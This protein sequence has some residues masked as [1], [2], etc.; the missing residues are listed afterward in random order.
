M[1]EA[2]KPKS[3]ADILQQNQDFITHLQALQ[4]D[5]GGQLGG[6]DPATVPLPGQGRLAAQDL[7]VH[8][9]QFR[10]RIGTELAPQPDLDVGVV[11]QRLGTAP[12]G[13]QRPHQRG[14]EQL[15]ERVPVG[16]L[17]EPVHRR[18]AVPAGQ[19]RPGPVQRRL[20]VLPGKREPGAVDRDASSIM[21]S[22]AP[23]VPRSRAVGSVA[24]SVRRCR[25]V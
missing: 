14:G 23:A 6:D 9:L 7:P 12:R 1:P 3:F 25:Q 15:V 8:L 16:Q 17:G 5:V 22:P 4:E 2:P 19:R 21:S 11:P 18:S 20:Q 10:P 13:V 24:G